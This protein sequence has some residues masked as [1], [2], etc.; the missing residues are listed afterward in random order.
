MG[1]LV[2]KVM[3]CRGAFLAR[4]ILNRAI[5]LAYKR[6]EWWSQYSHLP[7]AVDQLGSRANAANAGVDDW[8]VGASWLWQ[9]VLWLTTLGGNSRNQVG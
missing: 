3:V 6:I 8:G 4:D 9:V 5:A 7:T 1:Q 2:A